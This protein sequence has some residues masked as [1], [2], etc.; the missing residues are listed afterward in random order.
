MKQYQSIVKAH[1]ERLYTRTLRDYNDKCRDG[2]FESALTDVGWRLRIMCILRK[3]LSSSTIDWFTE[4]VKI[5]L[6]RKMVTV[7]FELYSW[8]Q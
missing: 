1:F 8:S 7:I 6:L 5:I 2:N 4:G 3:S